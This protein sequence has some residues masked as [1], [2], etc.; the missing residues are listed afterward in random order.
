MDLPG[1][2]MQADM[3]EIMHVRLTGD[4]VQMLLEIG[5]DLYLDC[6]TYEKGEMVMYVEL[7]K[8]LYG[9]IWA[10]HLF[11]GK[12]SKRLME[13][14]AN[15]TVNGTQ[16]TVVW[17]VDDLKLCHKEQCTV[18]LLNDQLNEEF[19]KEGLLNIL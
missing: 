5:K 13:C 14:I 15:K 17:H 11:W 1:A 8:A 18:D 16:L 4:M 7:L 12:L 2:F 3:D 6:V 19:G 9:T 10:A